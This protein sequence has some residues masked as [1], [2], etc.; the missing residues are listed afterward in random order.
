MRALRGAHPRWTLA[1]CAPVLLLAA[2][3]LPQAAGAAPAAVDQ[4]VEQPPGDAGGRPLAA[5][6]EGPAGGGAQASP[7]AAPQA[8]GDPSGGGPSAAPAGHP[9]SDAARRAAIASR[10]ARETGNSAGGTIPL[11]GYD[12][13]PLVVWLAVLVTAALAGR[14]L[15]L[16]RRR[17]GRQLRA[18]SAPPR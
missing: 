18:S 10:L 11:L 12:A 16:A 8:G 13:T 14:L 4:Y 7:A 15:W 9:R 1:A 3:A 5:P 2:A 17:F 6:A